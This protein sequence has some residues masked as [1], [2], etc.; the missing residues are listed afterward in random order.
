MAYLIKRICSL[1]LGKDGIAETEKHKLCSAKWGRS[2]CS[3]K[4][5]V[6]VFINFSEARKGVE[7]SRVGIVAA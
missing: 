4:G 7:I 5:K 6:R 3:P 2:G 1:F